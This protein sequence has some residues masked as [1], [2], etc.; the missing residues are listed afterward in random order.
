MIYLVCRRRGVQNVEVA[1]EPIDPGSVRQVAHIQKR[2]ISFDLP[3]GLGRS[4][5]ANR[6]YTAGYFRERLRR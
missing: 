3:A 2:G 5:A 6:G 1:I 4:P